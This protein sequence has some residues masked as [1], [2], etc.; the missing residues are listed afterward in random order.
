M[1][2]LV[3]VAIVGAVQ[4]LGAIIIN[5]KMNAWVD[6]Q[7]AER[8]K[9]DKEQKVE[10]EA[11]AQKVEEHNAK[12]D[13]HNDAVS[14]KLDANTVL[15]EAASENASHAYTEANDFNKRLA[16]LETDLNTSVIQELVRQRENMHALR[17]MLTPIVGDPVR[18]K[19]RDKPEDDAKP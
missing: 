15:T 9:A 5:A 11:L 10:R 19:Q 7:K 12:I 6:A 14:R 13:L 18:W 1:S 2:E 4:A 3:T 16:K 8:E 17:N